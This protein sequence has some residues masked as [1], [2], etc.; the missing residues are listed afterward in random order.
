MSS[1]P[2]VSTTL[3]NASSP[4]IARLA[5][6]ILSAATFPVVSRRS[7][8]GARGGEEHS[9][10][11]SQQ[12]TMATTVTIEDEQE[13]VRGVMQDLLSVADVAT[14]VAGDI[15]ISTADGTT[16]HSTDTSAHASEADRWVINLLYDGDCHVCMKQ[17]EFLTKRMDE[18]PEYAGLV[19][20]TNLADPS[21]D[22]AECGGVAFEDGMRHI[23]AVT[24]DGEVV[25]GVE[26]F[27]RV[28]A[29][30]GMEWVYN[31]TK[32][33]FMGGT[34][35]WLYDVW[36][37]HRL[38][39]TGREDVIEKVRQH[40]QKIQELSNQECEVECEIDWDNL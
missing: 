40:Q 15:A 8:G 20:L 21:Y 5:A 37:E 17:V 35:D 32:M 10:K 6:A 39:L 18:N 2:H 14:S 16:T 28:Y 26:V 22:P 9:I 11:L 34:F 31:L 24:R 12:T 3:F 33:P 1:R 36:A 13:M 23:H 19:H 27:R 38:H 29:A 7:R 30:I 25:T 4:Q